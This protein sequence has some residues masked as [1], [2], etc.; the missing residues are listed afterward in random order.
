MATYGKYYAVRDAG[1]PSRLGRLHQT[2]PYTLRGLEAALEDA[3]FRSYGKT[4]IV[5]VVLENRRSRVIRRYE[6]G[7]EMSLEWP[8]RENEALAA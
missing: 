2:Y 1:T 4:P 3:R 5:V 8:P 7:R 6:H